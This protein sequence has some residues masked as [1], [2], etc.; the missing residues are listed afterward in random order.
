MNNQVKEKLKKE[1]FDKLNEYIEKDEIVKIEATLDY[2]FKYENCVEDANREDYILHVIRTAIILTELH[3][4]TTCLEASLIGWIPSLV[5]NFEIEELEKDFSEE[6]VN[7]VKSLQKISKLKLKNDDE[8]SAIYL[9]KAI[10]GLSTDYRVIIIKLASRLDN[11]R[12]VYTKP[13]I[14]QKNKCIETENVLIPIA[15]RLGINYIKSELEDLCLKYLK[16]D[17]Y[18]EILGYLNAS[19]DKLNEY[20][21]EMKITLSEI[22]CEQNIKFRIKGRVKSVHSLYQKLSKGK[23]WKDIYDVLALRIIVEKESEC[24]L[25]IGL[26]HAKYRPIP[27]RF[28]D[29]IA[30]PK[31]NMYQSLHTGVIGPDGKIFEIQIRTEEMD[32]I[33]E[34]GIA[35]HWSY[36][37][38]GTK[39]I[40]ALMEQKLEVFREAIEEKEKDDDLLK[41]FKEI[42]VDKMIYVFTPKGDVIELPE[43]STPVDFAYRIHSKIGDT[44]TDAIVNDTIVP[45]DYKLQTD[46]IVKVNTN[47]NSTPNQDWLSFVMTSQAKSHIKSYFNKHTKDEYIKEGEDLLNK[48]L[49]RR[50]IKISDCLNNE[51]LEKISDEFKIKDLEDLYFQV[52]SHRY[53]A[54]YVVNALTKERLSAE[55]Q[56]LNKITAKEFTKDQNYKNDVIVK[57]CD[58]VLI[59][60]ANCCKPVY[61]EKIVGYITKGNGITVHKEDC[62]NLINMESRLIDVAWNTKNNNNYTTRLLVRTNNI[63]NN[64]LDIVTKS[65]QR[66]LSIEALNT[67]Q[68]GDN[69]DYEILIKVP[70]NDTLKQFMLDLE[71][72]SFVNSVEREIK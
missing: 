67:L 14:V 15:H 22:L 34:C 69:I 61:G 49:R 33:A 7:I 8:G 37:E 20:I 3:S 18:E 28:K 26:I 38:H 10:V 19:Y 52:G 44:L 47:S 2:A 6:I 21:E 12:T 40:Q 31:E 54:K 66:N 45:L 36:K 11:L 30:R 70:D 68:K 50:S 5:E 65:S 42:F 57:G 56:V 35:S 43:G 25:A 16:P 59:T 71:S 62:T 51:N 13:S 1:L 27:K 23:K 39:T 24:Y 4:D 32:E 17:K 58:N 46:D 63:N 9:R 41:E 72:L 55:E 64:I 48:E 60:M 29:Y 53:T